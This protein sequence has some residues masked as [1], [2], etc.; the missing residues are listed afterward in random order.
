LAAALATVAA[1]ALGV[2]AS[3]ATEAATHHPPHSLKWLEKNCKIMVF[4]NVFSGHDHQAID[5]LSITAKKTVRKTPIPLGSPLPDPLI[6]FTVHVSDNDRFCGAIGPTYSNPPEPL[7]MT[8]TGKGT[9][10]F[11]DKT[12]TYANLQAGANMQG[13]YAF[14]QAR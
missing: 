6:K 7:H 8:Q 12:Q 2:V 3:A 5:G 11:T 9:F 4:A 10:T 14:A 13:M 1:L